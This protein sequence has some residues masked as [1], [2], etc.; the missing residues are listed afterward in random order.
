MNGLN[1]LP[2]KSNS[3]SKAFNAPPHSIDEILKKENFSL[4]FNA[5]E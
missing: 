2:L 5:I 1:R 4:S 3:L